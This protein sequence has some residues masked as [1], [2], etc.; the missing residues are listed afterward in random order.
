MSQILALLTTYN[1]FNYL[2]TGVLVVAESDYFLN[3][4][5]STGDIVSDLAIFYFIGI[6]VSRIGSLFIEPLLKWLKIIK[7][8]DYKDY[9]SAKEVD[10]DLEMFS[11]INNMYRTIISVQTLILLCMLL[12]LINA[13]TF[14]TSNAWIV[15]GFLLLLFIL[16]YRK[17][18]SYINIRIDKHKN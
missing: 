2:F 6:I 16:S 17:Q 1:L 11:E 9:L 3:L 7:F 18:T 15:V 4:H 13:Y 12:K 10:K 5:L 8:A 14:L